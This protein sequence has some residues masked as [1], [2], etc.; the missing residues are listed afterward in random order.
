MS[1]AAQTYRVVL[2]IAK[3]EKKLVRVSSVEGGGGVY[4]VTNSGVW[5]IC[6]FRV[7]TI[8]KPEMTFKASEY[9]LIMNF[10]S[11]VSI[12][13]NLLYYMTIIT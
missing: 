1:Y 6:V 8:K 7:M 13:S 2:D 10:D 3:L 5:T 11:F 4:T 12:S 9:L